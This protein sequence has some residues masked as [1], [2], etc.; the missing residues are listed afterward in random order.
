VFSDFGKIVKL[1][2]TFEPA[3]VTGR[4][5]LASQEEDTM[6]VKEENPNLV[7]EQYF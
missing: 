5:L 2:I 1:L 4:L 6:L 3:L 7:I